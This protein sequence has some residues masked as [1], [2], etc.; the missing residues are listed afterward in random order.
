MLGAE[1]RG[2]R[3]H[4]PE[5]AERGLARQ[6]LH[7]AVWREHE[8]IGWHVRQGPADPVGYLLGVSTA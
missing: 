4:G 2:G 3:G 1:L 7:A 5:L 6:V 8:L